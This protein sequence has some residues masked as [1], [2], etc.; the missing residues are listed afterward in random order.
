MA[1]L[2]GHQKLLF[3]DKTIALVADGPLKIWCASH[4]GKGKGHSTSGFSR[5]FLSVSSRIPKRP[6]GTGSR[7][8]RRGDLGPSV[9]RCGCGRA[10]RRVRR[11]VGIGLGLP[12]YDGEI[13]GVIA[14][15]D[16]V[17]E[18]RVRRRACH[19]QA[20]VPKRRRRHGAPRV[21]HLRLL[22]HFELV[23]RFCPC[24]EVLQEG[25]LSKG[26]SL[27]YPT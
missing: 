4:S 11:V 6:V 12:R 8:S 14:N 5:A 3:K 13:H 25:P 22:R 1:C 23:G 19:A 9:R 27:Q 10:R 15:Y 18:L 2:L 7:H 17:L 24:V 26:P 21:L 16:A 20:H